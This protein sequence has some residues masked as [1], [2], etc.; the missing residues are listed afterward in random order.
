M[1]IDSHRIKPEEFK[2]WNEKMVEKYDPDAFHHHPNPLIRFIEAQRV[3]AILRLLDLKPGDRLL[4]VG[5]GAGN[6]LESTPPSERFGVDLS[7]FILQKAKQRLR[8]TAHLFQGD[9][10]S[11]PLKSGVFKQ[12]IC[13]EVL[14]HLLDP[15]AALQE[16]GRILNDLESIE[17]PF[18]CPHGRPVII[19]LTQYELEKMFK[20]KL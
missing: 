11:L 17:N 8:E 5:C 19:K 7:T 16:M 18:T 6:V 13:S 15:S 9:A 3:R 2:E 10:Q 1:K 12:V 14:E 20:R 4:E